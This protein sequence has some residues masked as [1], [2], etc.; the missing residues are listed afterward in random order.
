MFTD[1]CFIDTERNRVLEQMLENEEFDFLMMQDSDIYCPVGSPMEKMLETAKEHSA[2]VVAAICALR[3]NLGGP[4]LQANVFP[5][6]LGDTYKAER[7]GTGMVLLDLQ[8]IRQIR[9]KYKGPF[10]GRTFTDES[11]TTC[12]MGEDIFFSN[13]LG[14]HDGRIFVDG[15]VPTVHAHTNVTHLVYRGSEESGRTRASIEEVA[16]ETGP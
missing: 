9:K 12:D 14:A 7:V 10:F 11:Q 5:L 4:E 3:R 2:H 6:E 16:P 13:V 8:R 1:R 15:R